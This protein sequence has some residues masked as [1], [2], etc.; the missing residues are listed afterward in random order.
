MFHFM[1]EGQQSSLDPVALS[2]MAD[3]AG[4][5]LGNGGGL[6]ERVSGSEVGVPSGA[7]ATVRSS[8]NSPED[9]GCQLTWAERGLPG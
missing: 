4:G 8:A 1:L 2:A 6:G 3:R 9:C 7:M 5:L